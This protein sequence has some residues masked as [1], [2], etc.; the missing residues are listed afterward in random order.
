MGCGMDNFPYQKAQDVLV[1]HN[2]S[3]KKFFSGRATNNVQPDEKSSSTSTVKSVKKK[4]P[5]AKKN[6]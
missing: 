1:R 4:K 2:E 3:E 6:S 5:K